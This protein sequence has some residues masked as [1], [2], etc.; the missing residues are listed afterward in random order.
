MKNGLEQALR[1]AWPDLG[2]V[3]RLD[4]PTLK[5]TAVAAD[6]LLDP[7][8]PAFT[9]LGASAVV[10]SANLLGPGVVELEYSGPDTVRYGIE[11][12]L[13][14]S[15]LVTDVRWLIADQEQEKLAGGENKKDHAANTKNAEK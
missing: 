3:T 14:D 11:L 9:S 4:D 8:R 7:I 10:L 1:N 6:A 2:P 13:L 15:P 5:L 12:S